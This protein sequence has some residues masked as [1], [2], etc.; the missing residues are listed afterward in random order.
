M[1][2]II[3]TSSRSNVF[4]N[5]SL[6]PQLLTTKQKYTVDWMLG[7][8]MLR[9]NDIVLLWLVDSV[10]SQGVLCVVRRVIASRFEIL[11]KGNCGSSK[12]Q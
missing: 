4:V 9:A 3:D 2:E 12:Y 6:F 11:R 10:S 1:I 8:N 7:G 5:L